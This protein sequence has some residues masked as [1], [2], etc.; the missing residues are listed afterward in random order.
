[1]AV[2][3]NAICLGRTAVQCGIV[4]ISFTKESAAPT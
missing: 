4:G 3:I 1:M 2:S